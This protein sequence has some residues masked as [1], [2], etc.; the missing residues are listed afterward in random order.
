MLLRQQ[1]VDVQLKPPS[2][3]HLSIE[4][5]QLKHPILKP[6]AFDASDGFTPDELAIVGVLLNP[7]LRGQRD[8]REL[9]SAQLWQARLL[10]NPQLATALEFPTGGITT[11]TVDAYGLDM[12]WEVS[13]LIGRS[14]RIDAAAAQSPAVAMDVAWLEWMVAESCKSGAYTL[15]GLQKQAALAKELDDRLRENLAVVRSAV[16]QGLRT[17]LDLTAADAASTQ[18][19]ASLLDLESQVALQKISLNRL[20]GLPA[21][22]EVL[23]QDSGDWPSACTPP[24]AETLIDGL[25]ERRLDL[26]G[27]RYGYASQESA[28]RAAIL[29]QFPKLSLGVIHAR[30]TGDVVTTG[31]GISLDLPIFDHNQAVIAQESVTRQKLFDEYVN[32]FF[33]TRTDICMLLTQI[34]WLNRQIA[35]A[36]AAQSTQERL[37]E[38]YRIAVNQGQA[39]VIVYYDTWTA[40]TQRRIETV[41]LQQALAEARLR[42]SWRPECTV[43]IHW[44]RRSARAITR[45]DPAA[46]CG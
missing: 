46:A 18:A 13:T 35:A 39:D 37:V 38:T 23:L 36:L 27:L 31:F 32:R 2:D 22:K 45:S 33:Q 8:R 7:E 21:E 40:L 10:P 20:L 43:W 19:H 44:P 25:A 16:D 30:D 6:I 15:M 9:A 14:A 17:E 4:A 12:N 11:D 41:K 29:A 24:S 5:D 42:W 26:V 3:E 28:L 34:N 1:A